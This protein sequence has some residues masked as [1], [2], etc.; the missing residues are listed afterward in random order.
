M[1][2]FLVMYILYNVVLRTR[3]YC[4][5]IS[6]SVNILNSRHFILLQYLINKTL[7]TVKQKG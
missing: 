6:Y 2:F 4:M 3:L 7:Y 5:K 1:V